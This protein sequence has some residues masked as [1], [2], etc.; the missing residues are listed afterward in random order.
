MGLIKN[1]YIGRTFI[2]PGQDKRERS[3]RLKLN[4]LRRT[5]EGKRVVMVDDS[6]VRGTTV[7]RLVKLIR[8]AGA[9]EV[10]MRI[11]APPFRHPCFFGTDIPDRDQLLA[12]NRT[13]EEMRQIIGVDSLGFL[14]VEAAN[15]IAVGAKCSFCD[16]CFTGVYPMPVP[17]SVEK[18]IFE[19]EIQ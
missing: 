9:K 14:S 6:I 15:K 8:D 11:S 12:H 16:A 13:V 2:Q 19:M 3:V 10:H 1:R 18:N 5:V 17:E 7:A 4:A